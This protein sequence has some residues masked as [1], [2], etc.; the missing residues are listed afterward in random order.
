MHFANG[1]VNP[2]IRYPMRPAQRRPSE[3]RSRLSFSLEFL[4][5]TREVQKLSSVGNLR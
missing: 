5:V 2:A 4:K 3:A 1:G